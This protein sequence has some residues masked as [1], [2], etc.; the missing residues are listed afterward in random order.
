MKTTP[1]VSVVVI[2]YLHEKYIYDCILNILNQNY[3]NFEILIFDDNSPDDTENVVNSLQ[4]H[5]NFFRLSYFRNALNIGFQLNLIHA[6]K[7]SKGEYVA[8]CEGDD[9]WINR[10]KLSRQFTFLQENS[11]FF[12]VVHNAIRVSDDERKSM[13]N[14]QESQVV[15]PDFYFSNGNDLNIPTASIFCRNNFKILEYWKKLPMLDYPILVNCFNQGGIYYFSDE[16]SVY[17]KHDGGISKK[18]HDSDLY[19]K[20]KAMMFLKLFIQFRNIYL[21]KAASMNFIYFVFD[22]RTKISKRILYVPVAAFL[23]PRHIKI[24]LYKLLK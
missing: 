10:N 9:Y 6:I 8:I 20:R 14:N 22:G 11:S 13:N 7:A 15:F 16:L 23:F 12:A 19:F 18:I 1:L 3:E 21:L 5:P 17:R 24:I 2:T 4:A